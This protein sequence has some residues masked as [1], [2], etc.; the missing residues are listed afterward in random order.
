MGYFINFATFVQNKSILHVHNK[1]YALSEWAR[2][3]PID[4][5]W[6]GDGAAVGKNGVVPAVALCRL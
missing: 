6:G 3:L 1:S 5:K 4:L 2:E